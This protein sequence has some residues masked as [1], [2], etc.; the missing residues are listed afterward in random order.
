MTG[1]RNDH[2][3]LGAFG[4]RGITPRASL[5]ATVLYDIG[6]Q[7]RTFDHANRGTADVH[8]RAAGSAPLRLELEGAYQFGSQRFVPPTGAPAP[9]DVRAWLLGARIGTPQRPTARV[10]ATLGVDALSG[11]ASPAGATYTA[12]NTLYATNHPFYGLL[13]L[14]TDPA[15]RT[16]ERGLVDAFAQANWR[17]SQ[18]SALHAELHR[19]APQALGSKAPAGPLGWEADLN[20][21]YTVSPDLTLETGYSLFRAGAGAA[22]LSLGATGQSH[23]WAY[24]QLRAGF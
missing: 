17:M 2:E 24:L 18:H 15:A 14:F 3:A 7:Y 6:G 1:D 19:F 4:S 11:D 12:F 5:D 9:Q 21:P 20:V 8:L 16:N 22:G 13:D 10:N 23:H